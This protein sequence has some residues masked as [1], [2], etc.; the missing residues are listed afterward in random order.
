VGTVAQ[1]KTIRA[2]RFQVQ[3]LTKRSWLRVEG[4]IA[5]FSTMRFGERRKMIVSLGYE[6]VRWFVLG[7]CASETSEA[8]PK[9]G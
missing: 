5:E 1:E 4:D 2:G 9:K 7:K 8:K 3:W 6:E